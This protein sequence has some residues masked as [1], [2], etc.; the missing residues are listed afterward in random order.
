MGVHKKEQ[1][2][3]VFTAEALFSEH[4]KLPVYTTGFAKIYLYHEKMGTL[5]LER[6][7]KAFKWNDIF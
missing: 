2:S 4:Q 7:K 6:V 5:F 3:L 1:A